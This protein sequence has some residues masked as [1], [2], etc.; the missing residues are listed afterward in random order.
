M[1]GRGRVHRAGAV[2]AG[3]L[4]VGACG[5]RDTAVPAGRPEPAARAVRGAAVTWGGAGEATVPASV[6]ARQRATLAS[7]LSAAV[8]ALPFREGDH[9]AAGDVLV[10]LDNRALRSALAASEAAA[11]AAEA[12]LARAEALLSRNAV[13]PRE[14]EGAR[15]QGASARASVQAARD[16]LAYAVLRAPFAGQVAARS[17]HVGDIVSPGTPLIEIEGEAGLELVATVDAGQAS[18]LRPNGR[19]VARVDGQPAPIEATVRSLS[20]AG[21]PTTHRFEMRADLPA[22]AGLRSGLFARL[23]LPAP[24]GEAR[25]MVPREA[26]FERGGLS[27]VFVVDHG[28]ARLR[29]VAAGAASGALIEVRAGLEPGETVVLDHA[30]LADGSRVTE[31]R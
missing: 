31:S 15:A 29:W 13:T 19:V 28:L 23:A 11:V 24:E 20:A 14:A 17:V 12:E 9:V 6:Q 4:A 10:R 5:R 7:R 2:L 27:G 8:V 22:A 21:D 25:L 26:V 30:G 16:G 18:R 3:V 1:R